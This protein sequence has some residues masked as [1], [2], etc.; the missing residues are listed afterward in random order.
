MFYQRRCH[1]PAT[2]NTV[3]T[4]SVWPNVNY[5]SMC[6]LRVREECKVAVLPFLCICCHWDGSTLHSI[7]P[8]AKQHRPG[9]GAAVRLDCV[10]SLPCC[11]FDHVPHVQLM[12][13]HLSL[14]QCLLIP[15]VQCVVWKLAAHQD[16]LQENSLICFHSV[17]TCSIFG[18]LVLHTDSVI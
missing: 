12:L 7:C 18:G 1:K 15:D 5:N 6:W 10:T 4:P 13:A 9:L 16:H 11:C 3:S 17:E 8:F 14:Y 2:Q